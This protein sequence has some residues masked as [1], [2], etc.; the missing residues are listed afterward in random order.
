MKRKNMH[1]V[2]QKANAQ[3]AAW[4]GYA[5]V[6]EAMRT[7]SEVPFFLAGGA[8]RDIIL[9]RRRPPKDFD[10]FLGGSNYRAVIHRLEMHGQM[11]EG[12]FGSPRWFP[13]VGD[14][15]YADIIPIAEFYNG[16]WQ[17]EDIND[18]L[19]QFDFTGNAVAID[20]RDGSIHDP[21]NGIRDLSRRI[22]KMVRFDY[23]DEPIR[24]A[25]PLSRTTVLWFRVLHY[26]AI[27]G[28]AI[29][30]VTLRW[31]SA[32]MDRQGDLNAFTQ[33][34]FRPCAAY[35]EPFENGSRL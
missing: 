34:F 35:I 33:H 25:H 9:E 21:Q 3:L 14:D 29:E 23:P 12:P 30:P 6:Q 22:M 7:H 19:N 20:M 31:L 32:H 5:A 11:V 2:I 27:L 13:G 26:A 15:G 28:L 4:P 18:V 16:L 17:C 8:V 10:F 24:L 1:N